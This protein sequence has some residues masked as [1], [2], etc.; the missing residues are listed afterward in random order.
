MTSKIGLMLLAVCVVILLLSGFTSAQSKN[1]DTVSVAEAEKL[2]KAWINE[3]KNHCQW[4]SG[5]KL[6]EVTPKDLQERLHAQVFK[7]DYDKRSLSGFDA[8][9]IKDRKVYPMSINF[10]GYGLTEMCVCDIDNDSKCELVY[11]FS[12]GSGMHRSVIEAYRFNGPCPTKIPSG[13]ALMNAD[14]SLKKRDEHR[15][16]LFGT[17]MMDGSNKVCIGE[18]VLIKSNE[19][20]FLDIKPDAKLPEKWKE[21][22]WKHDAQAK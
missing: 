19:R 15:I 14:M 5:T 7:L 22:I 6:K 9:L 16:D 18:L 1:P 13:F 10:G 3:Q 21:C 17:N 20:E 11:I 2:I 4:Q 12:C 8:Y